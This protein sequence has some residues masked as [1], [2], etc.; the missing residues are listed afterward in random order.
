MTEIMAEFHYWD[1]GE[2]SRT[3]MDSRPEIRVEELERI[4]REFNVRVEVKKVSAVY[5]APARIGWRAPN[6]GKVVVQVVGERVDDVKACVGRV[7]L[8]YGRPDEVPSA[9]FGRKRAGRMVIEDLLRE[10]E[11]R[12]R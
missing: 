5:F 7:F 10:F 6:Y 2:Y 11:G 3:A 8:L 1:Y 9:F 12:K 4:A